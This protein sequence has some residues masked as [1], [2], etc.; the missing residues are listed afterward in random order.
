MRLALVV[1]YEGTNYHGFQ[2]QENASSIQEELEKAIAKLTGESPRVKGAGRTD[3]GVHARGQ[4]VVFDTNVYHPP[5][6]L[7]KAINHYLPEDIAIKSAHPTS[8]DFDPRRMAVN[9][10]YRYTIDC[11]LTPSPLSRRTSYHLGKPLDVGKMQS[12]ADRFVGE[13]DFAYFAGPLGKPGASTTRVI[14]Y[15]NVCQIGETVTFEV[16]GNAFLPHQVRRMTGA[17][18]DVGLGKLTLAEIDSLIDGVSTGLVAHSLP[19]HGLCLLKVRYA[20]FPM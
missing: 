19:S 10:T 12:A 15:A 1:E 2:Y 6:T 14:Y 8:E 17:L 16:Q 11:S 18:V 7:V 5:E 3:S 4:V 20:E 13:H 9:R